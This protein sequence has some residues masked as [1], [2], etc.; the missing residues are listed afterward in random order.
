MRASTFKSI[1]LILSGVLF[2]QGI[3]QGFILDHYKMGLV[4]MMIS[5]LISTLGFIFYS[6]LYPEND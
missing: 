6:A 3:A 1:I 4:M 5:A 2:G